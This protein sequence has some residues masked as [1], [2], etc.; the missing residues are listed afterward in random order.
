MA[1]MSKTP[2][3]LWRGVAGEAKRRGGVV[4]RGLAGGRNAAQ[5]SPLAS[6]RALS[7]SGSRSG[8]G[9]GPTKMQR[10]AVAST[11]VS[12][13][14]Q[15]H[16]KAATGAG[17]CPS[18]H[19]GPQGMMAQASGNHGVVNPQRWVPPGR[20]LQPKEIDNYHKVEYSMREWPRR[21]MPVSVDA[22]LRSMTSSRTFSLDDN[23]LHRIANRMWEMPKPRVCE[24]MHTGK[25]AAVMV[26][27]CNV[28]GEPSV[29]FTLR[30]QHV[31]T[32]KGQVSFPGG[33]L[34]L[35]DECMEG[36]ANRECLE[37]LGVRVQAPEERRLWEAEWR[38]RPYYP[39]SNVLGRLPN[40][41][42]ITGTL[43]TPVVGYLGDIK[44][45]DLDDTFCRAE[46]DEVF[47]ISLKDL[48]NPKNVIHE[49]INMGNHMPAFVCGRHKVWGLTAYILHHFLMEVVVPSMLAPR[50][51]RTSD[52]NGPARS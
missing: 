48:L 44:I 10:Q 38:E 36:C 43:V 12:H 35:N 19:G 47:S 27:L 50:R 33:H 32:H 17:Q 31:S 13:Q 15:A 14:P 23:L 26:P 7:P 21:P 24:T 30:S 20:W 9:S 22:A 37:E 8:V 28:D 39:R 4:L 45:S 5:G 18:A 46:I 3:L 16:L 51:P 6:H 34:D 49:T 41:V 11:A 52:A 2:V 29:L 40:C 25:R 42:A 1:V